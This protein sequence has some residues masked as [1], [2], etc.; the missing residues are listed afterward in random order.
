MPVGRALF[1]IT[2]LKAWFGVINQGYYCMDIF[3]VI[4]IMGYNQVFIHSQLSL[5]LVTF[6]SLY[7]TDL[8]VEHANK[9]KCKREE[10]AY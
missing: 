4:D 2:V 7:V 6:M 10:R 1:K 8:A 9:L 3:S 5:L